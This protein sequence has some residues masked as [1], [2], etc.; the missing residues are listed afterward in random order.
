MYNSSIK[1]QGKRKTFPFK[2]EIE[3]TVFYNDMSK[4]WW[5]K[6]FLSCDCVYSGIAWQYGYKIFNE[7]AGN[8]PNSYSD[9][10]KNIN[11][12]IENLGVPAFI[13]GGK[14]HKKFFPKAKMYDI[15]LN[16][17]GAYMP[18]CKLFVWNYEQYDDGIKSTSELLDRLCKEFKK[19]LDFSCGYGEHLMR[20]DEFIAC[21]IDRDCLTY[22]SILLEERKANG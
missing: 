17:S 2:K 7:N 12:L 19:P 9:Y 18:N 4:V 22:L 8:V 10:C 13:T 11:L 14:G 16:N 21:D 15:D 6:E 3:G 5:R 1:G 20:F